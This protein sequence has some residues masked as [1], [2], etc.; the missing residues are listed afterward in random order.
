MVLQCPSNL[1]FIP[2]SGIIT[3]VI[4]HTFP[5]RYGI[6]T[7]VVG[8]RT[9]ELSLG[10]GQGRRNHTLAREVLFLHKIRH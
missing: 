5:A 7:G 10:V 8:K 6:Q 2:S 3:S 1:A 9:V 4:L